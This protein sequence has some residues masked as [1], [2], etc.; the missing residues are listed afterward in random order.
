MGMR[1]VLCCCANSSIDVL[2]LPKCQT[3]DA[4]EKRRKSSEG[5]EGREIEELRGLT[6]F[7]GPSPVPRYRSA[8]SEGKIASRP[9]ATGMRKLVSSMLVKTTE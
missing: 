9:P 2:P 7:A 6:K 3:G 1:A 4:R 8:C 5:K